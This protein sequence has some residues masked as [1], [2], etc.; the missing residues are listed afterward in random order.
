MGRVIVF[1]VIETLLDLGAL[2][3]HFE[4]VFHD[5]AARQEWFVQMLQSAFVSI[6]AQRLFTH[7]GLNLWK[8]F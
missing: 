6:W 5:A 7:L 1:D 8:F 3:E 4:R 2:D